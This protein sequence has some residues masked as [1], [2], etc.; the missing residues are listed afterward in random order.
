[1][2]LKELIQRALEIAGEGI[3]DPQIRT[4]MEDAVE[5]MLPVV[6]SEVGASLAGNSGT[7][8]M[9]RRSKILNVVNGTVTLPSDV[10][11][12]FDFEATLYDP[13][14]ITKRYS[15]AGWPDITSQ[16]LDERLGH[17]II[18]EGVLTV[19][20]PDSQYDPNAGPTLTVHLAIPCTPE[21]PAG[22]NDAVA[23][24]DAVI[25]IL[26]ARLARALRP[27]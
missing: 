5:A 25:D 23:V 26:I 18:N 21:V 17:F 13:A 20:E 2:T 14:D 11:A 22:I 12:E 6:F 3:T 9:L 7:R 15:R 1:M 10:L 4:S 16:Q 19:I 8:H 27:A 24:T